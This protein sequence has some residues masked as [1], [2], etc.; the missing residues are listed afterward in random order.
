MSIVF[1][2]A[3][4]SQ[5][6]GA[7]SLS[8]SHTVGS[9]SNRALW[10]FAT[11]WNSSDFVG[12][13]TV[14]VNGTS[15]GSPVVSVTAAT[16]AFTYVWQMAAPP[17]GSV[18]VVITPTSS[19]YIDGWAISASGVDQTLL[20]DTNAA[21]GDQFG[22]PFAT[23]PRSH[24]V[25]TPSG[26]ASASYCAFRLNPTASTLTPVSGNGISA[27]GSPP[28]GSFAHTAMGVGQATTAHGWSWTNGSAGNDDIVMIA[29]P[30]NAAAS[31]GN[32][33]NPGQA[34]LTLTGYAPTI[35]QGSA[36][37]PNYYYLFRGDANV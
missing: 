6:S 29:L 37:K 21:N 32:S 9:G 15:L 25:T 33:V 4:S 34:A 35:A 1:D 23:S 5:I 24:A 31:S 3:T 14:T 16:S 17:T 11:G 36:V 22:S 26:G 7:S 20:A 28:S 18:T 12:G 10:I 19:A 8:W 27:T 13:A 30:I 2:T